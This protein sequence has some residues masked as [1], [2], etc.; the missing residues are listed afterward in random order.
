M[1]IT[2]AMATQAKQDFLDGVHLPTDTY[3]WVL[4][5]AGYAGT[6][7]AASTYANV[8]ANGDECPAT[9]GYATG[10]LAAGAPTTSIVGGVAYMDF[11]DLVVA[12]AT[13]SAGGAMLINTSKSN[14]VLGIWNTRDTGG[15][16]ANITSTG[17]QFTLN[18]PRTGSGIL[19]IS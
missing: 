6:Y 10:G 7:G 12:N 1:P 3:K 13:I 15:T 14:K 8:V 17:A 19:S 9:G 5:K 18:V 16:I 2:D 11:A 4:I